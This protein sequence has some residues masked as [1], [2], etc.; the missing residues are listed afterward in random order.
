MEGV[1]MSST[2]AY[3][4]EF[5]SEGQS[6]LLETTADPVQARDIL[7]RHSEALKQASAAG[8]LVLLDE[9]SGQ[10][11]ARKTLKGRPAS[12]RPSPIAS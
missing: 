2:R 12:S 8:R 10:V 7:A 6:V 5:H 11:L 1:T 9:T 4:L 3:R